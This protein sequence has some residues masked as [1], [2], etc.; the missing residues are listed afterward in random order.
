MIIEENDFK[1]E[2]ITD[3]SQL[4]DLEL[5]YTIKPKGGEARQEFKPAA[6]GI[7]IEAAIRKIIQ[8]RISNNHKNEAISLECYF[9]EFK[10]EL[11]SFKNLLDEAR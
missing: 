8:N 7:S 1:L 11:N 9:S 10:E 3:S 4:Y 6:Y 5:L 2:S